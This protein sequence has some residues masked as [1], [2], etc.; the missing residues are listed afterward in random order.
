MGTEKLQ[1]L[2]VDLTKKRGMIEEG[3][4]DLRVDL[5]SVQ[6]NLCRSA[7]QSHVFIVCRDQGCSSVALLTGMGK[8]YE[9]DK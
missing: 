4:E 1:T 9:V 7:F 5:Q 3:R 8:V 6:E 2:M